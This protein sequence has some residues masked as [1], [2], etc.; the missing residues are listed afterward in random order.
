MYILILAVTTFLPDSTDQMDPDFIFFSSPCPNSTAPVALPFVTGGVSVLLSLITVPG[1]LLV[2]MAVFIDP[3]KDL[4]SPFMY[5][6]ANLA[7]ADLLVGLVTDPV[8]AIY[9]I[10]NALGLIDYELLIPSV[11]MPFF[12][13]CTASVL[14]LAALTVDRYLAITSPFKYRATL[15]TM[16]AVIACVIVWT[17]SLSF[18]FAYLYLGFFHYAFLFANTAV[19][20]TFVVLLFAYI[21]IYK[22]FRR[23]VREWDSLHDSTEENRAKKVTMRW[24][25]KITKTLLI[26]LVLFI[27][28]YLPAC[29]F[30]YVI[31]LCTTCDCDLV[32]WARDLQ[33]LLILAN[34]SMNPFIYSWRLYN[35][36]RAFLWIVTC[37]KKGNKRKNC[38]FE[39]HTMRRMSTP[40]GTWGHDILSHEIAIVTV[41]LAMFLRDKSNFVAPKA[42]SWLHYKKVDF[43][44]L[45]VCYRPRSCRL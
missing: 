44:K 11:H 42:S 25:Q 43:S 24:E 38:S 12:I 7:M 32:L 27:S 31:N 4:R 41:T 19:V 6:V 5:F 9:H 34:S 45:S 18:P 2:V 37:G 16:R 26:M 36:R 17:L 23:Q 10:K 14:S 40:S 20:L 1:N 21:R 33:F 29:A 28:C 15:N 8:S 22:I 35:C 13:S 39:M 3:N 30:I